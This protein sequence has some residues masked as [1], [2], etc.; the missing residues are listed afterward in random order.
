MV[1][2]DP[3]RPSILFRYP[4]SLSEY[5]MSAY[6]RPN[7]LLECKHPALKEADAYLE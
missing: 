4:T 2:R 3:D 5:Q 1:E 6:L 7:V